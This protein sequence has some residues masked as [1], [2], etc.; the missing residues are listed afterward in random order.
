MT[1]KQQPAQQINSALANCVIANK[2]RLVP[3]LK[4]ILLCGRQNFALRAHDDSTKTIKAHPTCNPGNF[5][6]LLEFIIDAG[7][8]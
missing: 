3:M 6:A 5:K 8:D 1:R 4:T 7:D 2:K